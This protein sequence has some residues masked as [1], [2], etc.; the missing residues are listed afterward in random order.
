MH[1]KHDV[2]EAS[3]KMDMKMSMMRDMHEKM[4]AEKTPEQ[5]NAMMAGHKKMM[6]EGMAMMGEMKMMSGSGM[7]MKSDQSAGKAKSQM[8]EKRMEMME[9]MMQMMI[10]CMPE[11]NPVP[12]KK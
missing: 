9:T 4:M 7:G 11:A 6:Q 10:D 8:M 12:A 2:K 5:R 3:K 1:G